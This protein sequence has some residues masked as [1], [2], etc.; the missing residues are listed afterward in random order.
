LIHEQTPSLKI[1]DFFEDT[2]L[3]RAEIAFDSALEEADGWMNSMV[4]THTNA[5]QKYNS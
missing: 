4:H 2:Y 3:R 1:D 5:L